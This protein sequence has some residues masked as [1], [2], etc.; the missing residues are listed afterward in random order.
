M[1]SKM[2]TVMIIIVLVLVVGCHRDGPL[3]DDPIEKNL[4]N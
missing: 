1:I 3:T 2:Q 4:T